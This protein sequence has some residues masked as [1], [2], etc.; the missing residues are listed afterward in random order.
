[1]PSPATWDAHATVGS[2]GA[3]PAPAPPVAL[4][5][6]RTAAAALFVIN[7][8]A[9][10]NV[11]PRLPGIKADL[12]LSNAALGT[13]IAAVPAGAL[14]SGLAAGALIQRW[15]SARVAT[16]CG[17]GFAL[18]VPA[19]SL[20]GSWA[21]LAATFLV[22]GLF[23]SIMDVSMN[24]HA[25]RVQRGYGRSIVSAMHGLWSLGAVAG[26]GAGSLVTGLGVGL[27]P[28]L[29]AAGLVLGGLTIAARPLLLPGPDDA[30]RDD[31][32][33]TTAGRGSAAPLPGA[34]PVA[35]SGSGSSGGGPVPTDVS[36][37]DA[38]GV[39]I[40]GR[41]GT[42]AVFGGILLLAGAVED[43]PASWGAVLLRDELGASAGVGGL[44]FVAFQASMTLG[45]LVADRGVDR[46]GPAAVLRGGSS[47]V[48]LG[49][50]MGLLVGHPASVVAG[51]AVAGLGA[52]PLFPVVFQAAGNL[53]GLAT[54]HGVAVVAWASRV[55]FLVVPPLVGLAADAVSVR[56][57]LAVVPLAGLLLVLLA[58]ATR[59]AS[60]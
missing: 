19:V 8:A 11:V 56:A 46:F 32:G 20:A 50:G 26:A 12:G 39:G 60:G 23:D 57:A 44:V 52:A 27:R 5:R 18:V 22:F 48:V 7:A 47:A 59:P 36:A 45:R 49:A 28:H 3:V 2:V 41:A 54:G 29:L 31:L 34:A 38:G 13:A 4:R 43:S 6:A 10:A 33:A 51:F 58:G 53:P 21:A 55:G 40:R 14:L 17:L 30:E 37:V 25:L 9:Y 35:A 1:M 42:L 16:A 24:A 15:G